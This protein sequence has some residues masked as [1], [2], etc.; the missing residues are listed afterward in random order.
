ME[1]TAT[2]ETEAVLAVFKDNIA[3]QVL[4]NAITLGQPI[5]EPINFDD[6]KAVINVTKD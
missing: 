2:P 3:A 6:F 4:A 5:G 1:I